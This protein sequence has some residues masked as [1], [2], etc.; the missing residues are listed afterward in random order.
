MGTLQNQNSFCLDYLDWIKFL[1]VSVIF[2]Q[3]FEMSGKFY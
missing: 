2:L 1:V 3:A